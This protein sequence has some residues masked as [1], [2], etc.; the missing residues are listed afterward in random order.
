[1]YTAD[2]DEHQKT[3]LKA[4]KD[5]CRQYRLATI[6]AVDKKA[7]N[8]EAI[9]PI[10]DEA[11]KKIAKAKDCVKVDL[12]Y[13][14]GNHPAIANT[15]LITPLLAS[16]NAEVVEAAAWTLARIANPDNIAD[17]DRSNIVYSIFFIIIYPF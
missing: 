14:M 11:T 15:A 10:M 7:E 1:M 13:W 3:I 16:E 9:K 6:Y 8:E 4:L 2:D 17:V 5:N 12:L